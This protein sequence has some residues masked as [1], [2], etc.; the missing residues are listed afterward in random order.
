MQAKTIAP[1]IDAQTIAV[2]RVDLTRLEVDP[3][4]DKLVQIVPDA[5]AEQQQLRES[6]KQMKDMFA[7]AGVQQFFVAGS[8]MDVAPNSI[9]A[10]VVVP[11]VGAEGQALAEKLPRPAQDWQSQPMHGALILGQSRVLERLKKLQPAARPQLEEAFRAAGDAAIQLLVLPSASDRRVVEEL[12][13][14]LP[15]EIGGGP[16]TILTHGVQWLA[17]GIDAPPKMSLKLVVQSQDAAAAGLLQAKLREVVQVLSKLAADAGAGPTDRGRETRRSSSGTGPPGVEPLRSGSDGSSPFGGRR[18]GVGACP[19]PSAPAQS[20]NNLKQLGLATH[21]YYDQNKRLP[22]VGTFDADGKPLLSWRV[23]LLPYLEQKALYDQF[24]LNEPWDSDHNRKLISQMPPVFRGPASKHD[25]QAG[26]TVYREVTGEQTVFPGREGL[27]F[28]QVTDGTSNTILYV[29]VDD[30]HA[31]LW[32]K[33]EGLPY[34]AENPGA[35]LGGQFEGGFAAAYCDGS[36]R[37]IPSSVPADTLRRL[38]LRDD[39]QPIPQF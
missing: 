2:V 13:P 25:P 12:M 28:K 3:L 36:V 33:P 22:A 5:A 24:H 4:I 19:C 39:G 10:F 34:N 38:L 16:S 8:L 35:G 30:Q 21:V 11:S 17:L 32:T 15:Q 37:F 9:P 31:V 7:K 1:F 26:L 18:A 20:V 14:T 27:E 29:E 23:Q 6:L